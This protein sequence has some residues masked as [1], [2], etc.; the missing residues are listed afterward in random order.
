VWRVVVVGEGQW[1][2]PVDFAIR[3]PTP[4]GPGAPCRDKLHGVP[5]LVDGRVAAFHRRGV[6]LPPPLVVADSWL[7]DS[8]LMCHVATTHQGTVR[9]DGQSPSVVALPD[10]RQVKGE[11]LPPQ[12]E[13]PWRH[14]EQV[15]GGR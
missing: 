9:V 7:S 4:P 10:G 14:S 8:K 12:R 13:W 2:V 5:S 3:R 1:V 11:A 6:A 15:P